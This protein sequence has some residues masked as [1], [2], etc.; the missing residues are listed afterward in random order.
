MIRRLS[1]HARLLVL[2]ALLLSLL[3]GGLEI[4]A[5]RSA[6]E[7]ANLELRQEL[8]ATT[9]LLSAVSV[10]KGLGTEDR[11]ALFKEIQ[12]RRPAPIGQAAYELV[13][14]D[15]VALRSMP[16]PDFSE[17]PPPGIATVQ[18]EGDLWYVLTFVDVTTGETRRAALSDTS[19]DR[20][21]HDILGNLTAPWAIGLPLFA[22]AVLISVW[23]GLRPLRRIEQRMALIPPHDPEPLGLDPDR[24]PREIGVLARSFDRLAERLAGVMSDQRIFASAASH[25]LRTPLAGALSQLDVLRRAPDRTF[26]M[27]R[28]GKALSH[29]DRLITQ[30]LFLVRSDTVAASDRPETVDLGALANS[31][32]DELGLGSRFR[33]CGTATVTGYPDLLRSLARN[34]LRNADQASEGKTIVV[35]VKERPDAAVLSVLDSGAGIPEADRSRLLE[36]FQRG[37]DRRSGGAGLG[38][39]VAQRIA[40]LHGGR[41]EIGGRPDGGAIV[42][43]VISGVAEGLGTT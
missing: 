22:I 24:M 8:Q 42:S 39:T 11:R 10:P 32:G 43:A 36:P 12:L 21:A 15:G 14:E 20:R 34:L 19:R 18:G 26:A 38:L 5:R 9:D 16:F 13:D 31:V 23:V 7:Q 30:L 25:E 41:I 17:L 33:V 6:E 37:G 4:A 40:E 1:L 29:M 27:E 35:E 2:L 3:W 28:L